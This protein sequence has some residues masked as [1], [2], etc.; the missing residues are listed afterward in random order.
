M[1]YSELILFD[2]N[3][4]RMYILKFYQ[5]KK[6]MPTISKSRWKKQ[7]YVIKKSLYNKNHDKN[8]LINML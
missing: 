5:L 1:L 2:A 3:F 6:L 7:F 8:K 4:V